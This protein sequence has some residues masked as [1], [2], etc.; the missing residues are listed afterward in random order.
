M[1][2]LFFGSLFWGILIILIGLSIVFKHAFNF[3]F[4]MIK[5][6]IGI[7]IVLFG[8]R[9]I[10][11][12]WVRTRPSGTGH[13]GIL[14]GAGKHEIVFNSRMIDLTRFF[15]GDSKTSE[16]TVVFGNAIVHV[17]D[18]INL[19]ITATTVFGSSIMPDRSFSGFGENKYLLRNNPPSSV[20]HKIMTN[21]VFG[22]LELVI[23]PIN[24]L[25]MESSI[26][27]PETHSDTNF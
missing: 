22:K 21:T 16:I 7:I 1:N 12:P 4:P 14:Q 26:E 10:F 9:L 24:T 27:Q 23:K 11:G 18:S 6:F 3:S 17:P 25:Q 15:Q 2:G 19:D 8:F 13:T 20:T 5:I